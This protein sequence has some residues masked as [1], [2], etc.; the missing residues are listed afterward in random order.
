MNLDN[1]D[2]FEFF[3]MHFTFTIRG[4]FWNTKIVHSNLLESLIKQ[5]PKGSIRAFPAHPIFSI[6]SIGNFHD[7]II[8]ETEKVY[9]V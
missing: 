5:M 7:N 6:E 9:H 2:F 1:A 8:I 3:G 4:E